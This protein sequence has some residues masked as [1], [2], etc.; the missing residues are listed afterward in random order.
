MVV[1]Q[2][3]EEIEKKRFN[4]EKDEEWLEKYE[5][6]S[7]MKLE[8]EDVVE[9]VLEEVDAKIKLITIL[10]DQV[11]CWEETGDAVFSL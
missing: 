8:D 9:I 2:V 10:K 6:V 3:E 1:G 5:E 11:K 7:E 4:R